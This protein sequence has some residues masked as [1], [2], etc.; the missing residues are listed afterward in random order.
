MDKNLRIGLALELAAI[1][2]W[3]PMEYLLYSA[4]WLVQLWV[5][6]PLYCVGTYFIFRSGIHF[7]FKIVLGFWWL[8][9]LLWLWAKT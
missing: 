8:V 4:A 6:V 9:F 3:Q 2:L 1:L 5:L 7:V